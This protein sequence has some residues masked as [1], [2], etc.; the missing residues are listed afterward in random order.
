VVYA[1]GKNP[2]ELKRIAAIT[3]PVKFAFAIAKLEDKVKVT[4]KKTAPPPERVIKGSAQISA[5]SSDKRLDSLRA[6]A[7][8][9]G[10]SNKLMAYKRALKAAR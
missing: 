10:N 5:G 4:P 1:L 7:I 8:K 9:T 2:A 3:E 6:E